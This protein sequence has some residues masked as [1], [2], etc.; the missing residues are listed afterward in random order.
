MFA[1]VRQFL[2]NNSQFSPVFLPSAT[3]IILFVSLTALFSEQAKSIFQ[4][5]QSDVIHQF[6]WFYLLAVAFFVVFCLVLI[7]TRFGDIK[8]GKDHSLPEYSYGSWFSMLFS[9][10]MGIGL[11]FYGVAEPIYHYVSPPLGHGQTL[12]AAENAMVITFFHWG[13]HAWAIYAVV[14]LS[15]AYFTFRFNLPLTI[16]STLYPLIGDRIYGPIGHSVNTFAVIGTMFGVSTSLGLGVLQVNAGLDHLFGI[17]QTLWVQVI[18]ILVI[19]AIA[20]LSV[21]LGLDTGIKRISQLNLI[22][23]LGLMLFVL[24]AGSTVYL[25]NTY[26]ENIG[27]YLEHFIDRT[28]SLYAYQKDQDWLAGW[29]LFYWGWWI[30]WAPFV[31]MFIARISKGRT[32]R[33]FLSGVLF[34]P[35]AFT[36]LWMTVFGNTSLDMEAQ[37]PGILKDVVQSNM[38][39]SLYAMLETFPWSSITSLLATILIVTFFVTSS[40]SGSL[41][42]DTLTAGGE[43]HP[44]VW[45]RI[46][47]ATSEGLVAATLLAAGG[48]VALQTASIISALPFAVIMMIMVYSLMIGLSEEKL[49]QEVRAM[50]TTPVLN[51]TE[52]CW[53]KRLKA[54]HCL[55]EMDEARE[56]LVHTVLPVFVKVRDELNQEG[57][58]A[59]ITRKKTQMSIEVDF[60]EEVDFF[61]GIRLT[62]YDTSDVDNESLLSDVD[63]EKYFR[64]EVHLS[65]GGQGYDVM[66]YSEEQLINDLLKQYDHHIHFLHS[67]R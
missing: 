7:F 55:P 34:V 11:I 10:G 39:L 19:T 66:G 60:G 52:I 54:I 14:G 46:F 40:D 64:A 36:F 31:G 13:V 16:S 6:G 23:A 65:E 4:T 3:I 25:L 58:D 30:A 67:L 20:T 17:E 8:L 1:Q 29:T 43:E 42:I 37:A 49:K 59:K 57:F 32:I 56:Y 53:Q 45:Q 15:L 62:H 38:P 9:A 51:N 27:N 22:L 33:E 12:E 18:L 63:Q 44:F 41:V 61:Y 21:G 35:V 50:P 5:L 28:F 2:Q 24:F 47:W 48:L 26:V